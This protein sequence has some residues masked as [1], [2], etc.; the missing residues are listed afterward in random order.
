MDEYDSNAGPKTPHAFEVAR[1]T[2][3]G[4]GSNALPLTA[5]PVRA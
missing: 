4:T 2:V 1:R 5:L 3:I